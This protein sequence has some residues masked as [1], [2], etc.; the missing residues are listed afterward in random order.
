M[1][2][3]DYARASDVAD[4][5]VTPLLRG[6]AIS[7]QEIAALMKA[8]A[9]DLSP[10]GARDAAMIAICRGGLRRSEVVALV[11]KDFDPDIGSL[12]IR[13]GKGGKDRLAY[14]PKGSVAA[15]NDWLRVRGTE[16]STK[17]TSTSCYSKTHLTNPPFQYS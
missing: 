11:V 17:K 12:I 15:V 14:L 8:C 4:I 1:N 3:E 9:D 6:R 16:Q 10:A 7:R 13:Q 5:R 2:G